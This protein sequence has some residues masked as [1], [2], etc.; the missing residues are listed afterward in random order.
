MTAA[1]PIAVLR[2]SA[3]DIDVVESLID[4][5]AQVEA[6]CPRP[7][8]SSAADND[9]LRHRRVARPHRRRLHVRQRAP[10]RRRRGR[11]RRAVGASS[12]ASWSPTTGGS[13]RSTSP[14]RPPRSSWPRHPGRP[15]R[16]RRADADELVRGRRARGRPPASSSPPA[17][18]RGS[19]TGSRS[20]RRPAAAG[21]PTSSRRSRR[22]S[23][24][25]A[26]SPIDR[27]PLADAEAAGLVE[28]F[29]PFDGYERF[30]RRT[31]DLD[32]LRAADISVL[33]DPLYGAGAGWIPRLLAGGSDPRPR[34]PPGAQPVLRRAQPGADPARTSMRRSGSSPGRLRPRAAP[35]RGR[36]PGRRGR[37]AGTFIHQLQV[38]GLLMYYLAEHRGWRD[39]VVG[40]RQ[41]HV[42]GGAHSASATASPPTR[43]RSASSSSVRR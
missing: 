20:R 40:Q 26:G 1:Q 9:R 39:P 29:D 42:D 34:D 13:P 24:S 38:T 10:L 35:R 8:V 23:R 17:T 22:G 28:R 5:C 21:A 32:A 33:V 14:P 36:R 19:T 37:R 16:S 3:P 43:R 41:Q 25:T 2:G 7:P 6:E 27:R 15:R 30:V 12:A 4:R 18:T 31:V 11:L